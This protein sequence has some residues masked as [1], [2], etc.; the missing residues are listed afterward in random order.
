MPKNK[1]IMPVVKWVGGKRQIISDI[2]SY[3]PT[4]FVTFYEPFLGGGA[5]FFKLQPDRAVVNDR[6][7]ELMNMYKVIRDNVEDLITQLQKHKNEKEHFYMVRELDRDKKTYLLL[8]DVEKAARVIY[9]NKTCYNGLFRVNRAGEFNTPYGGYK[10]P[11]IFD[12][13]ILRAVSQFLNKPRIILLNEDFETALEKI[14][15]DSFV[16]FDPPY[17]PVSDTASFTGYDKG[18]FN[19]EEQIRLKKVCDKLN[20]RGIKFLLSNSATDFIKELYKDY[21]IK[22]VKAR[23]A[24][25][26]V[27]KKRGEVEE[28][29]VMNYE[30]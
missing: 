13:S 22:M 24:I 1:L 26:S 10:N 25:N 28:L 4:N 14:S 18:G 8:S 29:L 2:I 3:I 6:N 21:K 15:K 9:L 16:Y 20:E 17:D 23:R 11:R 5:V 7:K 19:R 30:R 27:G 12:V